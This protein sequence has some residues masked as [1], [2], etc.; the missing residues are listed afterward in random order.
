MALLSALAPIAH[1]D[2]RLLPLHARR[3][4]TLACVSAG[5]PRPYKQVARAQ[6]QERTRE[7]LL[8][9]ATEEFYEGRWQQVSLQ[10]LAAR[11]GVTKQTLLR[12][13]GSKDQ[14]FQQV[15]LGAAT[16]ILEQRWSAPS[17]DVEGIVENLLDHY[18]VWGERALRVG[19]WQSGPV[20]LAD[21]SQAARQVHYAWVEFAF[22]PW[23]KRLR[24]R[25]RERCRATLIALCDVH[26]WWLLSHDLGLARSELHATL[27][28]I[29]ERLLGER[30]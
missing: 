1:D 19:D 30:K 28:D 16:E 27:T 29:I 6:A 5:N 13:F 22:A 18:E 20:T 3:S 11:A 9:A 4:N 12:H 15:L 21:F 14:L 26:V 10:A 25:P 7:A 2:P 24:G 17:G 8:E 23:L